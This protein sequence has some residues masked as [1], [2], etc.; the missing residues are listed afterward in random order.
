MHVRTGGSDGPVLLALHGLGATGAVWDGVVERWPGRWIVPDLPGH[1]RSEPLPRYSFGALAAAVAEAVPAGTP[2]AVLGHS[3]GGVVA[4]TLASGWFGVR[5]SGACGLGMKVRW[6]D[7]ELAR[8]ADQAT[9]PAKVFGSRDEAAERWLK[10]SGLH[11]L[12]PVDSPVVDSGL[13]EGW[14]L[15]LDQ[16]AFGVGAPDLDGLLAAARAPVILAAGEHDP[17]CPAAHLPGDA[18][19]LPGLGHN[20]HVE[21]PA[22]L[23]PLLARLRAG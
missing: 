9:R 15:A 2:V 18:V 3:L 17:M 14:R 11:G 5:V 4:L 6:T 12:V 1:G 22:A 8:A 16:A 20:A 19:L 7:E 23:D 21:D 10:V 13:A